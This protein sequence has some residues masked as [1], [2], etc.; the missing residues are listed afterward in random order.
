MSNNT[1]SNFSATFRSFN[2]RF[3]I[4]VG[5]LMVISHRA[6]MPQAATAA[7]QEMSALD[8]ATAVISR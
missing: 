1:L 2:Q 6:R 3:W 7:P 8:D 5:I 4:I